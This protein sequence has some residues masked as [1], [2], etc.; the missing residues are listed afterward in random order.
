MADQFSYIIH[1]LKRR[2]RRQLCLCRCTCS[3]SCDASQSTNWLW[4]HVHVPSQTHKHRFLHKNNAGAANVVKSVAVVTSAPPSVSLV[5]FYLRRLRNVGCSLF[6]LQCTVSATLWMSRV[7][8]LSFA[9]ATCRPQ[10]HE[11]PIP[12]RCAHKLPQSWSDLPMPPHLN[13]Q[14][15]RSSQ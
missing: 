11:L 12:T 4:V 7:Q 13:S 3:A 14:L 9:V 5:L 15:S 8:R 1:K 10:L 6:S 2:V